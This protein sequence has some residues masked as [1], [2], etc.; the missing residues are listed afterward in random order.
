LVGELPASRLGYRLSGGA[1]LNG[2]ASSDVGV[3]APGNGVIPGRAFI[4]FGPWIELLDYVPEQADMGGP[5]EPVDIGPF[6]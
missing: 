6:P 5:A 4:L 3:G 2:D 1:S